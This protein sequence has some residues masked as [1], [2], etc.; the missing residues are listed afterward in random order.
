MLCLQ[1]TS[2]NIVVWLKPL[3]LSLELFN[4]NTPSNL[5]SICNPCTSSPRS[6]IAESV[7]GKHCEFH[8]HLFQK[9]HFQC[10]AGSAITSQPQSLEPKFLSGKDIREK[11]L[12]Y[13][14]AQGHKRLPSASLVPQD[15]T[16]MLT[17]AG[18]LQFKPIFLGQVD[19]PTAT[20]HQPSSPPPRFQHHL[21]LTTMKPFP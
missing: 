12:S 9:S 6:Q 10:S 14:E 15:P 1:E 20:F 17:I 3:N 18:M 7:F 19:S 16:V 21:L 8:G 13:Y 5:I 4:Y 2:C 11:F